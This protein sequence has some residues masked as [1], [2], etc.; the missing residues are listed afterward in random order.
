ML[1]K[2]Y[3]IKNVDFTKPAQKSKWI[4]DL[5]DQILATVD[6]VNHK[7]AGQIWY[8]NDTAPYTLA[9][10][11]DVHTEVKC[12][13]KTQQTTG[14]SLLNVEHSDSYLQVVE[15]GHYRACWDLNFIS[16][17]ANHKYHIHLHVNDVMVEAIE[18]HVKIGN[19][20]DIAYIGATACINLV[21]G[22]QVSLY[23]HDETGNSTISVL[24]GM[25]GLEK[26]L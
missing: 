24:A 26:L 13:E 22:D 18:R 5:I 21:K 7:I 12:F 3:F 23:V 10:V 14:E 20:S 11:K 9:I 17:S 2:K 8:H 19:A 6:Y 4:S 16:S 25:I 15:D 1:L